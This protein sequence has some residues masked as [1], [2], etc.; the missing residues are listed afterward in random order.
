MASNCQPVADGLGTT[1]GPIMSCQYWCEFTE[2]SDSGGEEGTK[3][4]GT[5][6]PRDTIP[7][8]EVLGIN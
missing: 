6:F 2:I 1:H 8:F 3:D 7:Q 4:F 5:F